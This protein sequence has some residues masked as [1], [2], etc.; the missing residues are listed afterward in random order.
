MA[1]TQKVGACQACTQHDT[2]CAG[3]WACCVRRLHTTA[4]N[5]TRLPSASLSPSVTTIWVCSPVSETE[6]IPWYEPA[7]EAMCLWQTFV[8]SKCV[9]ITMIQHTACLSVSRATDDGISF[10]RRW[11]DCRRKKSTC[12]NFVWK[13][14]HVNFLVYHLLFQGLQLT[15]VNRIL[16]SAQTGRNCG[17][18]RNIEM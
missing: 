11:K 14:K 5:C 15:L 12:L 13:F 18:A 9:R 10:I 1:G 4:R 2:T 8:S 6:F 16:K 7:V 3:I 17:G